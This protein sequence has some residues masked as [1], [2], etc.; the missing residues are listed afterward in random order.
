MV[1]QSHGK[2]H[3]ATV[4][5]KPTDECRLS[6]AWPFLVLTLV[7][8]LLPILAFA[9]Y[10]SFKQ[11]LRKPVAGTGSHR[12]SKN[13]PTISVNGEDGYGDANG[14]AGGY[15]GSGD[16]SEYS[17]HVSQIPNTPPLL[18]RLS[19]LR[20]EREEREAQRLL[21][22]AAGVGMSSVGSNSTLR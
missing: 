20:R 8:L 14:Y 13:A 18:P 4:T 21:S 11:Y 19:V 3:Y 9:L 12:T 10:R 1:D 2:S 15:A 5:G 6:R 16:Y 7:L 17:Q 22:G